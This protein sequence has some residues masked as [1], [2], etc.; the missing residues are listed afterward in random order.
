MEKVLSDPKFE[1]A[2][3]IVFDKNEKF[4]AIV[5]EIMIAVLTLSSGEIKY[6]TISQQYSSIEDLIINS[7]SSDR[8][9]NNL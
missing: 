7:T 1:V 9:S 3:N 8:A 4:I 5:T 2:K 6:I